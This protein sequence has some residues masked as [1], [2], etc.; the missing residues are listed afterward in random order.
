M[1]SH[2][3]KLHQSA[4]AS[5]TVTGDVGCNCCD[6]SIDPKMVTDSELDSANLI[7]AT[8]IGIQQYYASASK[9]NSSLKRAIVDALDFV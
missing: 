6:P 1:H 4:G 8:I 5:G 2:N 7:V 9:S 3:S